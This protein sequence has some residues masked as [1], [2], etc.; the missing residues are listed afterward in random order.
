[1]NQSNYKV[2]IIDDDEYVRDSLIELLDTVGYQSIA[3]P[4]AIDFLEDYSSLVF[5]CI[6][7]DVR[8]PELSG[9]DLH[10][11]LKNM[12]SLTPVIF[13]TGH[14]DIQM[15]VQAMKNGAFDFLQKPFRDQDI[16]DII[17][18]AFLKYTRESEQFA[19]HTQAIN[20]IKLLTKRE[21]E[22][23]DCVFAGYANKKIASDLGVSNRTIELHRSNVMRKLG[24]KSVAELIKI[25]LQE[26]EEL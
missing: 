9:L 14:G 3:Y 23:V 12:H 20:R 17:A 5:G 7:A 1:M 24:I 10:A 16:L 6:L 15:A 19:K 8:M 2:A 18:K 13:M 22:V 4:N 11:K 25:M 26:K 21:R